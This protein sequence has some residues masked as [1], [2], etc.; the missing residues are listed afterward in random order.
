MKPAILVGA[1]LL[2]ASSAMAQAVV[3]A[4]DVSRP[5]TMKLVDVS[6][7]E[8]LGTIG[9]LAGISIQWDA[10][11]SAEVRSQRIAPAPISFR[12]APLDQVLT[13]LTR[14]VGLA[15]VVVDPKTVR[16]AVAAR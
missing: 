13:A 4:L 3:P 16:I 12:D 14:R 15:V 9:R 11:V 10:A 8:A 7:D 2:V 6:L 5:V 1:S